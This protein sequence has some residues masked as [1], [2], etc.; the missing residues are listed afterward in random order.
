MVNINEVFK[1]NHC[2]I[3]SQINHSGKGSLVCCGEEMV[4]LVEGTVDALK[5]SIY[6][7]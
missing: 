2:G 3:I 1:C 5:K 4:K 7:K 6:Q